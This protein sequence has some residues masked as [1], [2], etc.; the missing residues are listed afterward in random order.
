MSSKQ[1]IRRKASLDW[2]SRVGSAPGDG[3]QLTKAF[4][5]NRP[6]QVGML[7]AEQA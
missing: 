2:R 7:A 5:G 3:R 6:Y 1:G 4:G